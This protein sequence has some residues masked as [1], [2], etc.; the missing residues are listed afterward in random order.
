MNSVLA[1]FDGY[2]L[3]SIS[4]ARD[5]AAI[6]MWIELDRFH[7][8]VMRPEFFLGMREE[9]TGEWVHDPRPNCY[10]LEDWNGV[11]MYIRLSRVARV[12]IQ[13]MP[14]LKSV[15]AR[16]RLAAGL[17]SGMAFLE[18]GL[19]RAG[20]EQWIFDTQASA[21]AM[22]ARTRL[23]FEASPHEYV[24]PIGY[25]MAEEEQ[26]GPSGAREGGT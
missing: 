3:R 23:G 15:E 19:A 7:R 9:R 13:F 25:F 12:H 14:A 4:E 8:D 2:T 22:L 20:A 17:V 16:S 5:R 1:Q 6:Q 11:L 18:V 21:L 26:P 10:A 24:R